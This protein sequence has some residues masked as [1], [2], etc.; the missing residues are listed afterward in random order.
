[1]FNMK[2]GN[3][4]GLRLDD[5]TAKFVKEESKKA[6][7]TMSSLIRKWITSEKELSK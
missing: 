3:F 7:E 2:K 4:F 6:N 5:D 1:M